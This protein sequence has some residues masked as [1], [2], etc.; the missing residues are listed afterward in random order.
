MQEE[1]VSACQL[2]QLKHRYY[3]Q[4]VRTLNSF[5]DIAIGYIRSAFAEYDYLETM[6]M[7]E[8]ITPQEVNEACRHVDLAR[9]AVEIVK[10]QK[11]VAV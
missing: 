10:P 3:G 4:S 11:K 2:D 5:D 8:T 9:K 1:P 6:D 7:I